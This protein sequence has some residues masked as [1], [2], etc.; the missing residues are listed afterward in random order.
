MRF[1]TLVR[2]GKERPIVAGTVNVPG[3][4]PVVFDA[5]VDTGADVSLFPHSVAD[6]L[7]LDL[8]QLP[9]VTVF[10]AIGGQC[11]YHLHE[12]ELELRRAPGVFRWKGS[13]GFVGR[14]MSYA[15]LGTRGFFQ[16]FDLNYSNS[17]QTIDIA[18]AGD[19]PA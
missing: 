8:S 18:P 11:H 10:A 3:Q 7:G 2:D 6:R 9:D 13:V 17:R 14:E 19:R 1:P 15:I 4:Y 12:V 5:L 16:H